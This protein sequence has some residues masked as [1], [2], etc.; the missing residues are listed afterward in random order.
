MKTRFT[1]FASLPQFA[2]GKEQYIGQADD[3]LHPIE[4]T[5]HELR[6]KLGFNF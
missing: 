2:V 3:S 6:L 4:K 1:R 5:T